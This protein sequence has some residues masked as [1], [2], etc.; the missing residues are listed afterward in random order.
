[1]SRCYR[2]G[3]ATRARVGRPAST[4]TAS[5]SPREPDAAGAEVR[6]ERLH[7]PYHQGTEVH[8]DAP[9]RELADLRA[10]EVEQVVDDPRLALDSPFNGM[11]NATDAR[12]LGRFRQPLERRRVEAD[13]AQR[14]SEFVCNDGKCSVPVRFRARTNV[15]QRDN[16]LAIRA[17]AE[18]TKSTSAQRSILATGLAS[19]RARQG[20]EASGWAVRENSKR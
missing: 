4:T 17:F 9:E 18:R 2:A 19:E 14:L 11:S 16:N 10:R 12:R 13:D 1:M 15:F 7:Q 8:F 20:L 3:A 5:Q 6:T